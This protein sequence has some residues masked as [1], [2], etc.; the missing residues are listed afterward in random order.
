MHLW[1]VS[2]RKMK[3]SFMTMQSSL[4]DLLSAAG[5]AA[6]EWDMHADHI[7]WFGAWEKL[8]VTEGVPVRLAQFP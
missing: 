6:Y 2:E 3:V 4:A 7:Q 5:D 8:L 1:I